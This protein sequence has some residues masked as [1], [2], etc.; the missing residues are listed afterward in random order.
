MEEFDLLKKIERVKAPPDFEQ[1]VMAQLSLRRERKSHR[2][3]S[4]RLSFALLAGTVA[5]AALI[6]V[7][8]NVFVLQKEG[9]TKFTGLK[10]DVP[11]AF[12]AKKSLVPSETIAIIESMDYSHEVRS[13]SD[14]PEAIYILEQV[15][16]IAHKGIKY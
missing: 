3:R 14:E 6:F 8:L 10:E 12:Q 9:P 16:D 5:A 7:C 4:F 2:L 11:T 1:K 15:S 13:L